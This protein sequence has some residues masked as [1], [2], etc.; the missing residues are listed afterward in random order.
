MI[1]RPVGVQWGALRMGVPQAALFMVIGWE[2][3]LGGCYG[4]YRHALDGSPQ[5]EGPG[6]R[7]VTQADRFPSQFARIAAD[8][9][10]PC[11]PAHADTFGPV[12]W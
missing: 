4:H 3:P 7:A 8:S 5:A 11:K 2:T 1:M 6:G 12:T 9:M 10:E